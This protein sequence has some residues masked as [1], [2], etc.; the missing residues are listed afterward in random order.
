MQARIIPR[1]SQMGLRTSVERFIFAPLVAGPPVAQIRA[2]NSI[3]A[4]GVGHRLVN[5]RTMADPHG[6]RCRPQKVAG[7]MRR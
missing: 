4:A 3:R 7:D 2:E 1:V 5:L 6:M